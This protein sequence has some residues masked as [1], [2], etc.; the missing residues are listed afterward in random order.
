[1]KVSSSSFLGGFAVSSHSLVGSGGV[2]PTLATGT[3]GGCMDPGGIRTTPLCVMG[4]IRYET[5][6]TE[7]MKM[8]NTDVFNMQVHISELDKYEIRLRYIQSNMSLATLCSSGPPPYDA[9]LQSSQ[10]DPKIHGRHHEPWSRHINASS[11]SAS[12]RILLLGDS[13]TSQQSALGLQSLQELLVDINKATVWR[14]RG[15][16]TRIFRLNP[17]SLLSSVP[18]FLLSSVKVFFPVP[19]HFFLCL[20]FYCLFSFC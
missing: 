2:Q 7:R 19:F 8:C 15:I 1:V 14:T 16:H 5:S 11:G 20:A 10:T 3:G 12:L 17:S 6:L 4:L 13:L 18:S 9:T